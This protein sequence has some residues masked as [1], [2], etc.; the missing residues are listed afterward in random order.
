[1]AVRWYDRVLLAAG[2]PHDPVSQSGALAGA[3]RRAAGRRRMLG[4]PIPVVETGLGPIA[5]AREPG[6]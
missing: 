5:E 4:T 6:A 3:D 1:M 2:P